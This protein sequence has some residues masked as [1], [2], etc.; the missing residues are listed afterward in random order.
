MLSEIFLI[1]HLLEKGSGFG[2]EVKPHLRLIRIIDALI[3]FDSIPFVVRGTMHLHTSY[4]YAPL[5]RDCSKGGRFKET[6][7]RKQTKKN[8]WLKWECKRA[9][10]DQSL[11]KN[12]EPVRN[13]RGT[14]LWRVLLQSY[15]SFVLYRW[16]MNCNF[17]GFF[18]F[19]LLMIEVAPAVEHHMFDPF[20]CLC[21]LSYWN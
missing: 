8:A 1:I 20:P 16:G 4:L 9:G 15:C 18:V 11:S 5:F 13:K 2:T 17:G 12:P 7:K 10:G 19:S 21:A 14:G 6:K 3:L